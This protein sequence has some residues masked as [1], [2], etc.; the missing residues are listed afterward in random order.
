MSLYECLGISRE[1]SSEEIKRAYRDLARSKHPD[2]GGSAAEF[3]AIQEA[4]EVLSDERRRRIY[5]MTG[6]IKDVTQSA[7]GETAGA[8]RHPPTDPAGRSW[9]S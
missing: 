7:G 5:D 3:Q 1:A 9:N 6:D 8:A 2:K 4:H